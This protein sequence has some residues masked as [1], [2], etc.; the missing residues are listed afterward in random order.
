MDQFLLHTKESRERA[1]Q[2]VRSIRSSTTC[3]I[4]QKAEEQRVMPSRSNTTKKNHRAGVAQDGR[5]PPRSRNPSIKK[6]ATVNLNTS[7]SSISELEPVISFNDSGP[8]NMSS[9]SCLT[10]STDSLQLSFLGMPPL[11]QGPSLFEAAVH[12]KNAARMAPKMPTR[13]L[14][15]AHLDCGHNSNGSLSLDDIIEETTNHSCTTTTTATTTGRPPSEAAK[16]VSLRVTNPI[17]FGNKSSDSV[18]SASLDESESSAS[19]SSFSVASL[20]DDSADFP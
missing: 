12:E 14:S 5:N 13:G 20:A 15:E 1:K 19:Y 10:G 8:L 3:R 11:A 2:R 6:K 18:T 4:A 7:I 9:L 17:A 16:D